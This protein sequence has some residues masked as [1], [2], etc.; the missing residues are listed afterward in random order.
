MSDYFDRIIELK[1]MLY[2]RSDKFLDDN[3]EKLKYVENL[4][5]G[6]KYVRTECAEFSSCRGCYVFPK[7]YAG[8][9]MIHNVSVKNIH[10]VRSVRLEVGG[11]CVDR[12]WCCNERIVGG[13]QSVYGI[14]KNN[15]VPLYLINS[16]CL[17]ILE[18]HDITLCVE[19]NDGADLAF[20]YDLY[21]LPIELRP[22]VL[23][24][25]TKP[26]V[27]IRSDGL[28][29]SLGIITKQIDFPGEDRIWVRGDKAKVKLNYNHPIYN[30][31]IQFDNPNVSVNYFELSMDEKL[32][33]CQHNY[34]NDCYIIDFM[35]E[36]STLIEKYGI[37]LSM[38]DRL[39]LTVYFN[40]PCL[41]EELVVNILGVGI[42]YYKIANGK[43]CVCFSK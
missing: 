18:V 38:V 2:G 25:E 15:N 21:E 28:D 31:L 19:M 6:A 4:L 11:A 34:K 14:T 3:F 33:R 35:P 27:K 23:N 41:D 36:N 5:V 12:Y 16:S 42:N 9:Y 8:K 30:L 17:P 40:P 43:G 37:N 20:E 13:L 29:N 32:F 22:Y 1:K 24:G 26:L 39:I 7:E 10:G